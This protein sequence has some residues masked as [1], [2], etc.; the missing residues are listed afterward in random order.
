MKIVKPF[1]LP[2]ERQALIETLC[3]KSAAPHG[4]MGGAK[5]D[6]KTDTQKTWHELSPSEDRPLILYLHIPFCIAQCSFCGFYRNQTN[7]EAMENYTR[8]LLAEINRVA[9]EG[10][11]TKKPVKMV[12]FGGGTPTALSARQLGTLISTLYS[13]FNIAS[14]VEFTIEGRIYN[15]DDE[16]FMSCVDSGANRF[17]F[18]VQSFETPLRQML[19]RRNTCEELLARLARFKELAG[20]KACLV[21]DLIY[22]LPG[23]T[24]ED[25]IEKNIKTTH[26]ESALDGVDLYSLKLFPGS[27]INKQMES[28]GGNWSEEE[29]IARHGAGADYLASMGWKQLSTTH[30]GR[31]ALERNLYNHYAMA[32]GEMIPFG[33]GAGGNA[34]GWAMM[35]IGDLGEYLKAVDEGRKPLGMAMEQP[36]AMAS[37]IPI[38]AQLG[39]GYFNPADFKNLDYTELCANW[40]EAGIW[41]REEDGKYRLTR[42]GEYYQP[43]IL[44]LLVGYTMANSISASDA[45]KMAGAKLKGLFSK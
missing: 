33:C 18:G 17:S 28:K 10:V 38:A 7:E 26:L 5:P 22:G 37:R 2:S 1:L 31:N 8:H 23:Q 3:K 15:F 25:W 6:G 21:A 12:Y 29:R 41:T 4:A 20:D 30:F 36:P 19:G 13:R 14:D 44:S 32:G 11:W 43:K 9:D 42:L 40:Q 24:Q 39:Y 35:Q 16:R 34:G 27:A 45:L